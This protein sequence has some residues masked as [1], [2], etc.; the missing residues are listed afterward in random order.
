[1]QDTFQ[2]LVSTGSG[3]GATREGELNIERCMAQPASRKGSADA[4]HQGRLIGPAALVDVTR[5][6]PDQQPL[7]TE[8]ASVEMEW[9]ERM[10][11]MT[12]KSLGGPCDQKLSAG[13]WNEMV[14]AMTKHVMEKHPD[15]AKAM[16]KMH[17]EDPQKWGRETKPKWEATPET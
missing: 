4:I 13:S 6:G 11:T 1:M 14:Q 15:T 5:R 9:G 10:K 17:N 3:P 8:G 12:C 7:N 2:I 16:E